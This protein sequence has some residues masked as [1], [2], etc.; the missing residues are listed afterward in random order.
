ML[1]KK[2][3][4]VSIAIH[5]SSPLLYLKKCLKSIKRF[6]HYK[7]KLI[8]LIPEGIDKE[9]KEYIA[10]YPNAKICSASDAL[11]RGKLYNQALKISSSELVVLVDDD[12]VVSK[13]WINGL[14]TGFNDNPEVAVVGSVILHPITNKI[15]HL[16]IDLAEDNM[17]IF[18]HREE[19]LSEF[20]EKIPSFGTSDKCMLLKKGPVQKA[21][22]FSEDYVGEYEDLALCLKIQSIGYR[23]KTSTSTVVYHY[24]LEKED[25]VKYKYHN[26]KILSKDI[27]GSRVIKSNIKNNK[28]LVSCLSI[29]HNDEK[30]LIEMIDSIINQTYR[31]W[32]LI[33]IDDASTDNSLK[34]LEWYQKALP[35]KIKVLRRDVY[36]RAEAW[37]QAYKEAR[38]EYI[39]ITSTDDVFYTDKIKSQI[40][41]LIQDYKLGAAFTNAV[42]INEIGKFQHY[43][44]GTIPP[45]Y[46]M[47]SEFSKR[48]FTFFPSIVF[49]RKSI[50]SSGGWLDP[51]YGI[52]QDMEL[53]QRVALH[54]KIGF[55]PIPL[56]NQRHHSKNISKV[57]GDTLQTN[58]NRV[59]TNV[60]RNNKIEEIFPL[61]VNKSKNNILIFYNQLERIITPPS[62]TTFGGAVEEVLKKVKDVLEVTPETSELASAKSRL[63][64]SLSTY[65]HQKGD[66]ASYQNYFSKAIEL[67]AFSF[68]EIK[69]D[70]A[71]KFL[72][73]A[74]EATY[75]T[76]NPQNAK[77]N[78]LFSVYLDKRIVLNPKALKL[79]L[80]SFLSPKIIEWIRK[81]KDLAKWTYHR[82]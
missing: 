7:Y 8:F 15:L 28:P 27:S 31:N 32:E 56:M 46:L 70:M 37:T 58:F 24:E 59:I 47:P 64:V 9:T 4:E 80:R 23:V 16:G 50:E 21:G 79:F 1:Y 34:I 33:L 2:P 73:Y 18:P 19:F 62:P 36:N 57:L 67:H 38:G 52:C 25:Q 11:N 49:T 63:Y 74:E 29:V 13:N 14:K 48:A 12:V 78:I 43:H 5:V 68:K 61:L 10:D 71:Q 45:N 65:F 60:Y 69:K 75:S 35:E 3:S 42:V 66:M 51:Y 72:L 55:I 40:D 6:T 17:P 20:P 26:I 44:Q 76:N 41:L 53:C 39:H 22:G 81:V 77:D 30:F 54:N 82:D